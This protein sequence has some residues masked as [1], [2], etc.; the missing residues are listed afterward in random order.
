MI[1]ISREYVVS[2]GKFADS[3]W[4]LLAFRSF[5]GRFA[6]SPGTVASRQWSV[7]PD[8]E[9]RFPMRLAVLSAVVLF[10]CAAL[11]QDNTVSIKGNI[12]NP[13]S[14]SVDPAAGPTLRTIIARAG[15]LTPGWFSHATIYRTDKA[16]I[17]HT[18]DVPL[19]KILDRKAPDV[20][21]KPGDEIRIHGLEERRPAPVIDDRVRMPASK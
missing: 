6:R 2:P 8:S 9:T 7:Y 10:S 16:G 17:A 4:Q 15:G 12:V 5:P 1:C 18:I 21:L 19:Q 14:Y 11:A 3:R 13:G 20:A